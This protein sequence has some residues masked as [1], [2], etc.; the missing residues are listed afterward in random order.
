VD[1]DERRRLEALQSLQLLDTP[2]EDRFDRI[3][4]LAQELFDVPI[5]AINLVDEH[6]QFTKSGIGISGELPREDSFCARTVEGEGQLVVADTHRDAR[7]A[8]NPLVSDSPHVRFYAGQPLRYAGERIGSLCIV[9]DKPRDLDTRE[10]QLLRTLGTWV[11]NELRLDQE[12]LQAREVQRRLLPRRG[13]DVQG[14]DVAGRCV[15]ARDVGGDFFD[16]QVVHGRL[17]VVL[18]DVMGKGITAAIVAAG[19]RAVMRGTS[20]FNDLATSLARTSVS[21]Q[22]DLDE[23]GSFVTMFAVRLDPLTGAV[24]YVDAGH[25]LTLVLS[26]NGASRPLRS[27]GL[28]L[29]ASVDEGWETAHDV[30]EPGEVMLLVSDG[31]L[32]AFPDV[33]EAVRSAR[34]VARAGLSAQEL[35]NRITRYLGQQLQP[36]DVTVVAIRRTPL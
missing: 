22:E 16:W 1:D 8:D 28:P 30:L 5:A 10:S 33:R 32:D 19:V 15:P 2:P 7:F 6:R 12:L 35:V 3:T 23:T 26:P 27:S 34:D 24:E 14:F 20:R 21:M 17:Q 11:E 36:D 9:D 31:V 25:G 29:G 4:R 13:P 18:A